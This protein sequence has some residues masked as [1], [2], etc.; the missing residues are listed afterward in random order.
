M[1]CVVRKTVSYYC[2]VQANSAQEAVQS[3]AVLPARA[4]M[5]AGPTEDEFSIDQERTEQLRNWEFPHEKTWSGETR[6][7]TSQA[8]DASGKVVD[9]ELTSYQ[10]RYREQRDSMEKKLSKEAA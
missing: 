10:K 2:V 5:A 9:E 3:S 4:W 6:R 7:G 1:K 8:V